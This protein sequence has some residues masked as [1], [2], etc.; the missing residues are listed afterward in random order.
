MSLRIANLQI[1]NYKKLVFADITPK[2]DIITIFG[3]CEQGKT[4]VLDAIWAALGGKK[5]ETPIHTGAETAVITIDFGELKVKRTFTKAGSYLTVTTKDGNKFSSPQAVIDK[6]LGALTFDPLAF[7]RGTGTTDKHR[8][9]EM[10]LQAVKIDVDANKLKD[11]SGVTVKETPNP[12]D[13]LNEAYKFVFNERT[14]ANRD[15]DKAKKLL[16]SYD[17]IESVE[18]V[19]VSELV[20]EKEKLVKINQDNAKRLLEYQGQE[21]R[22][23]TLQSDRTATIN[24]IS[25]LEGRLKAAKKSLAEKENQISVQEKELKIAKAVIDSKKDEDLTSINTKIKTADETNL[26]AQKYKEKIQKQSEIAKLK[27]DSEGLTAKIEAIKKYK[28]EIISNT[29]FPISGLDFANGGV[30]FEGLPFEQASTAQRYR[31]SVAIGMALNPDLRILLLDGGES[32]DDEQ[33][34]MITEMAA[35]NDYQLWITKVQGDCKV[36]IQT[37]DGE[38]RNQAPDVE[39]GEIKA[40]GEK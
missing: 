24:I 28:T 10:L 16:D 30:I 27:T 39:D 32:L 6:L 20:A 22:L 26:K 11:I 33:M 13:M 14:L 18:A 2:G 31:I 12:L 15:L 29:K 21:R 25:D 7:A 37:E 5:D 36:D 3:K 35:D 19:S 1:E 38:I 40:A 8:R 34:K 4:T 23:T 17:G 9:V